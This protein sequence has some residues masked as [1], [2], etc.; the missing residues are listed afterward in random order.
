[1]VNITNTDLQSSLVQATV[2]TINIVALVFILIAGGIVGFRTGWKGYQI[3]S[4]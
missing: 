1:M 3:S 2:T 4:G